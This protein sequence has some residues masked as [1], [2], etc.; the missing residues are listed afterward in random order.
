M[1]N[2]DREMSH[3]ITNP[4]KG[5]AEQGIR[6]KSSLYS[7]HARCRLR[8]VPDSAQKSFELDQ[9]FKPLFNAFG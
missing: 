8:Y 5:M 2:G 6:A 1:I 3:V 9:S 4:R 7:I